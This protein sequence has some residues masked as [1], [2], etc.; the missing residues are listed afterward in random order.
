M[1]TNLF[2]ILVVTLVCGTLS[3][4]SNSGAR[5]DVASIFGYKIPLMPGNAVGGKI[6][7]SSSSNTILRAIFPAGADWKEY[8]F[9]FNPEA[10]G[11]IY[12]QLRGEWAKKAENRRWIVYDNI[13]AK[14]TALDNGNFEKGL[15]FW[16]KDG[17]KKAVL[18]DG[19]LPDGKKAIKVNHDNPVCLRLKVKK[20]QPVTVSF[21]CKLAK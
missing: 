8:S 20:D 12:L 4:G 14:G 3:A 13:T 2:L 9:T 16:W 7:N 11:E 21:A 6:T 19:G 5:L 10:D 1:K 17:S 18:I 15:K